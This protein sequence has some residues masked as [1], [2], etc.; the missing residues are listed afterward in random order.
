MHAAARLWRVRGIGHWKLEA[1]SLGRGSN[2]STQKQ[3]EWRRQW[4]GVLPAGRR[5]RWGVRQ[6][7]TLELGGPGV[8]VRDGRR[9][10][11]RGVAA[12]SCVE[13]GDA[14]KCGSP[15]LVVEICL[16]WTGWQMQP[17]PQRKPRSLRLAAEQ[18]AWRAL[19]E[20]SARLHPLLRPLVPLHQSHARDSYSTHCPRL[21]THLRPAAAFDR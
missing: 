12:W 21:C 11:A 18:L 14:R 16:L 17:A 2:G 6:R 5:S 9:D 3:E 1:F 4:A 15:Q 13:V 7:L 19:S 8:G 20:P 10:L